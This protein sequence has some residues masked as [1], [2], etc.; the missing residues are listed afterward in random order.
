MAG[1]VSSK[2]VL[3]FRRRV[4]N[5]ERFGM[6]RFVIALPLCWIAVVWPVPQASAQPFDTTRAITP[7]SGRVCKVQYGEEVSV[8]LHTSDGVIVVDP[9]GNAAAAWV[10]EELA[11]RFPDQPV[12]HA[13]HTH[14]RFGRAGGAS[15]FRTTAETIGHARFNDE[16]RRAIARV[17]HH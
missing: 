7:I 2:A 12:R 8:F 5:S 6:H 16:R 17:E 13:I 14:H 11:Q 1:R 4:N 10:K 9:L 3:A 15:V